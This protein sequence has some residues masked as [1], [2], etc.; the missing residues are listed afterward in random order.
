MK[1]KPATIVGITLFCLAVGTLTWEVIARIAEQM[2]GVGIRMTAGPY[3]FDLGV[4]A[5]WVRLNPGSIIAVPAAVVLI[6][7]L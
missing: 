6:R 2:L 4:L 1:L 7:R 5:I 3:G